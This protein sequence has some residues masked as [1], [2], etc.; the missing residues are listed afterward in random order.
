M[1]CNNCGYDNDSKVSTCIKCGHQLQTMENNSDNAYQRSPVPN[2]GSDASLRPTVIGSFSGVEPNPK[3]TVIG[4]AGMA[5]IQSP[6][7]TQVMEESSM[8]EEPQPTVVQNEHTCPSCGYLLMAGFS[9]CPRC[10]AVIGK[11]ISNDDKNKLEEALKDM[12]IVTTCKHCGK[13]ISATFAHCPHCGEKVVQ[14]TIYVRRHH[15]DPPKPKCSLQLVPEKDEQ[16]RERVNSYEGKSVILKRDNTEPDNRSITSKSQAELIN[17]NGKWFII[18]HSDLN[19]TAVE[20]GRR[21]E[22]QTGDIIVLGDRRFR[23][24]EK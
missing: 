19:S 20:A 8:K 22:I 5:G 12:N 24:E 21:I 18:N 4:A 23:F 15:V 16:V 3:A 9:A 10:G 14:E 1:R 17:E 6:R 7:P 2:N 13:E 11:E